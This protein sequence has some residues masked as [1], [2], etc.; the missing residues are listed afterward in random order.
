MARKSILI[1]MCLILIF[2]L[3]A[4]GYEKNNL[5]IEGAEI[6]LLKDYKTS[7][8][9]VSNHIND[10]AWQGISSFSKDFQVTA[11]HY[12]IED[13]IFESDEIEVEKAI[14]SAVIQGAK[15]IVVLGDSFATD[16]YI[17][18]EK[19]P[20]LVFILLG[21]I[22]TNGDAES[23]I[24]KIGDN[25]VSVSIKEEDKNLM[26]VKSIGQIVNGILYLYFEDELSGGKIIPLDA[27]SEGNKLFLDSA[28]F[29]DLKEENDYGISA[30]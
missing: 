2:S 15:V 26:G 9:K 11:E 12:T 8:N 17:A 23:P 18:Q 29:E 30:N 4:C 20:D 19:Y 16:V 24:E 21:R 13:T 14:E 3:T 5:K 22:P 1:V 7:K 10:M 27:I 6:V 25:T 28:K